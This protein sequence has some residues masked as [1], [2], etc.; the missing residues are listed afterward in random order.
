MERL[1]RPI[2]LL[3]PFVWRNMR[4]QYAGSLLGIIWSVIQPALL[5]LL[6]WWVF[7]RILRIRIPLGDTGEIPFIVFLLSGLLPWFAFQEGIIK[8]SGAVIAR[9]DLVKKVSIPVHIFPLAAIVA[10]FLSHT[11]GF[12]LF[13]LIYFL[14]QW[15]VTI[16]QVSAILVLM[17]LQMAV[18]AGISLL[19]AAIMV[20]LRDIAQVINLL[21]MT[22]FYTA[23]ILYP[24]SIVP[25]NLQ[26]LVYLN[27]FATFAIAYRGVILQDV[28]PTPTALAGLVIFAGFAVGVGRYV[29][30]RLEPGFADVL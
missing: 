15:Q 27:P 11:I 5:I 21:L 14:W 7:S 24:L 20:Y 25:E 23:P 4:E 10:A 28:W 1:Q 2:R 9:R 16:A 29:F 30:K 17:A 19:C 12:A 6:Y 22:V 13:L 8:G 3:L 18:V 26:T